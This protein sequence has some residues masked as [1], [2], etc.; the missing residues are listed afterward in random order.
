MTR[1][2]PSRPPLRAPVRILPV[3]SRR[4]RRS[5]QGESSKGGSGGGKKA[6]RPPRPA[7]SRRGRWLRGLAVVALWGFIVVLAGFIWLIHD[8][9]DI[10]EVAMPQRRPAMTMTA[11]DGSDL[12]R[13]GD[14][15][16]EPVN[17]SDLPPHLIQAVL[18]IEDRRFYSHPG[19]DPIGILRAF[20][21][22]LRAG[23][24][25]QGGSTITQQLAKNL[26]LTPDRTM[27]RKLQEMLLALRL[28]A[29]YTKNQILTAYL[30]RAYFGAGTYGVDAAARAYFG[31]SATQVN[32][33]Q[34]AILAGLL[35]AP[36]RYSPATAPELAE[37]RAQ[38]VL[39]AMVDAGFITREQARSA[40]DAPPTP[41]R[42][43]GT[44]QGGRYFADWVADQAH[45]FVGYDPVDL[46]IAT[47]LDAELQRRAEAIVA[48][49]LARS[50]TE[51]GASQA[52]VVVMTTDGAVLAMVGGRSYGDSQFNRATQALRQPGSAFKPIVYLA[53][54]ERGLTPDT[55]VLDAPVRVGN[56]APQNIDNRYRGE[57]S[58]TAALATSA[59]S[60]A[61][62]VMQMAGI[63]PTIDLAHRLGIASE[64]RADASIALGTSEVTLIEL[65]AAYAAIANSGTAVWPYGI[66]RIT[67]PEGRVLFRRSG[68]GA[69]EVVRPWHAWE[70]TR[71]MTAVLDPEQHGTGRAARLDRPAAGKTGTTQDYRDA[72][73][74]GFT[75]DLVCGV[76]VGN[77]DRSPMRRVTGGGLPARIWHDVMIAANRGRP[78]RPLPG[79]DSLRVATA[80]APPPP[81]AQQTPAAASP[82]AANDNA[83]DDIADLLRRRPAAA[84]PSGGAGAAGNDDIGGLLRRLPR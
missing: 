64:L 59:N 31:V 49:T 54:I 81:A 15:A 30:N 17:V 47:T 33:H 12:A 63:R 42:R 18:A 2:S 16:G 77:D 45:D 57:I 69:G 7:R 67:D 83:P 66:S 1:S 82:P 51:A 58:A 21:A 61:V 79:S 24:T 32:L 26:F 29:T 78:V 41:R 73:F 65:T 74:V 11:A 71:M 72:W 60:A 52:A 46:T 23:R 22:N 39:A 27:R 55:L 35:Q 53:A 84:P 5:G 43:P 3:R 50:G 28:E 4:G 25:L 70:L 62:R 19:I 68:G 76:W 48:E 20:W 44:G 40:D 36:S 75:A 14:L 9:P 8:L 10:N 38:T 80:D 37:A 6:A 34:A 56:W 13:Y